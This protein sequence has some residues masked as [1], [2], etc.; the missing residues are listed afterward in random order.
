MLCA[1]ADS[2]S[3]ALSVLGPVGLNAKAAGSLSA[4]LNADA[5]L[6]AAANAAAVAQAS[7]GASAAL[8]GNLAAAAKASANLAAMANVNALAT[9]C[10]NVKGGFGIDLGGSAAPA[11]LSDLMNSLVKNA[12]NKTLSKFPVDATPKLKGLADLA[13]CMD[14][15][16]ALGVNLLGPNAQ[17]KLNAAVAA[18]VKANAAMEAKASAALGLSA[19]ATASLSSNATAAA[20]ANATLKAAFNASLGFGIGAGG[21]GESLKSV[22]ANMAALPNFGA[23]FLQEQVQKLLD[24]LDALGAIKR[25]LNVDLTVPGAG[26]KLDEAISETREKTEQKIYEKSLSESQS[27]SVSESKDSNQSYAE[28]QN[29]AEALEFAQSQDF[30][31]IYGKGV[32]GVPK[33]ANL[34]ATLANRLLTET[35]IPMAERAPCGM[36][37]MFIPFMPPMC[38]CPKVKTELPKL[39]ALKF[40][41]KGPS[42]P[43]SRLK[44]Q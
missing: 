6:S 11:E 44:S 41:Q 3:K 34:L 23:A 13:S 32:P 20:S 14:A 12:W 5:K 35:G 43:V 42:L 39:P 29:Y 7:L 15:S 8:S 33:L 28:Q 40:D 21:L 27:K 22:N 2:L 16:A 4:A 9:F 30:N 31:K 19:S 17:A 36:A 37:C 24:L 1:C 18:S 38:L 10:L 25:N 26:K